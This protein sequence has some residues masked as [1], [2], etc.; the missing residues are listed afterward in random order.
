LAAPSPL[1]KNLLLIGAGAFA[2]LLLVL[3]TVPLWFNADRFR[4]VM[5]QQLSETLHRK[6]TLGKLRLHVLPRPTLTLASIEIADDP[7]FGASPIFASKDAGIRIALFSLLKK[8]LRVDSIFLDDGVLNLREDRRQRLNLGSLIAGISGKTPKGQAAPETPPV[9]LSLSSLQLRRCLINYEPAGQPK[10]SL[11]VDLALT[12]FGASR[13]R[14]DLTAGKTR[15]RFTGRLGTTG[16]RGEFT[17]DGDLAMPEGVLLGLR[18]TDFRSKVRITPEL[19]HFDAIA[20]QACGGTLTADARVMIPQGRFSFGAKFSRLDLALCTKGDTGGA[21]LTGLAEASANGEGPLTRW[22]AMTGYATFAAHEGA[23]VRRELIDKMNKSFAAAGMSRVTERELHY[24]VISGDFRFGGGGAHT[25]NLFAS[26]PMMEVTGA[27]EVLFSNRLSLKG[28][29]HLSPARS[30][31]VVHKI[32]E[33]KVS[34]DAE[35]RLLIPYTATGAADNPD[36]SADTGALLKNA[37]K[38]VIKK[39]AK[40]Y[41]G[42]LLGGKKNSAP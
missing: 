36:V 40:S 12:G 28:G 21:T 31:E 6:V 2:L 24:S 5:E 17:A 15:I 9:A 30:A 3:L 27:G 35:N 25:G 32:N 38:A 37:G 16:P 33:L 20:A 7:A 41:L 1:L 18:F 8:P 10:V 13:S 39:E 14:L 4:P 11:P 22:Q 23:I 34:L 19:A 29:A 26:T 42:G